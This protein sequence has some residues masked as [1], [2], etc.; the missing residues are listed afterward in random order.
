[1]SHVQLPSVLHR[2]L[3]PG[4]PEA[5]CVTCFD[6]LDR[7]VDLEPDGT[8]VWTTP[9]GHVY[10]RPPHDYRPEPGPDPGPKLAPTP[11]PDTEPDPPPF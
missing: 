11:G 9:A 3:G 4:Q 6:E 7:Y 10:R 1:M 8:V 5:T 2:L